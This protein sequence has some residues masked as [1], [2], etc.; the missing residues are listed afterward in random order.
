MGTE[1]SATTARG[2][3]HGETRVASIIKTEKNPTLLC[4]KPRAKRPQRWFR[5]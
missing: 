5:L 4:S 2:A 3:L 1:G